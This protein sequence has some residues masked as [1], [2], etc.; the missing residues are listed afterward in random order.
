MKTVSIYFLFISLL[1]LLAGCQKKEDSS[2][3][4]FLDNQKSSQENEA[5]F[6]LYGTRYIHSDLPDEIA[7]TEYN[8]KKNSYE[9]FKSSALSFVAKYNYYKKNKNK[10]VDI[11]NLPLFQDFY[12]NFISDNE[13]HEY[14]KVN[15][16]PSSDFTKVKIELLS[17]SIDKF[18]SSEISDIIKKNEL[19]FYLTPPKAPLERFKLDNYPSLGNP[20]ATNQIVIIGM[21]NCNDCKKLLIQA[22]ELV[23]SSGLKYKLTY[24]PHVFNLTDVSNYFVEAAFCAQSVDS[25]YFWPIIDNMFKNENFLKINYDDMKG[26]WDII[27]KSVEYVDINYDDFLKCVSDKVKIKSTVQQS[28]RKISV[29][30]LSNS[31]EI[32]MNGIAFK[33]NGNL[34]QSLEQIKEFIR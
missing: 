4:P 25:K 7:F 11:N 1:S 12:L 27:N 9:D 10:N 13:V 5:F 33:F 30:H 6:S 21:L 29:L 22:Q 18:L 8:L 26:A 34:I 23:N 2:F 3:N 28:V 15:N 19:K 20:L 17:S 24:I 16:L 14:I 32:F 31:P